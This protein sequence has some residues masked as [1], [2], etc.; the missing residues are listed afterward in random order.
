MNNTSRRLKIMIITALFAAITGILAQVSIPL[1]FTQVPITGQ[2]LAIGLVATILGAKLGVLST[3]LY[4]AIGAIGIPV[5]AQFSAGPGVIIGPT[6]GYLIGFI[7]TVFFIGI[8][9]DQFG[10]TFIQALIAN[11]LGM[12][13]TLSCGTAWLK[14]VGGLTFTTAFYGGFAPFIF[15]GLIK[16]FLASSLGILIRERLKNANLLILN[17]NV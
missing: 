15:V 17:S 16:A 13:I 11:V 12:F 10:Y 8:W 5:F 9:L 14:F 4:I 3:I 7:P 6:G 2:T 1:P